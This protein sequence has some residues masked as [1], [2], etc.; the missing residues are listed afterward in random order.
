MN[1]IKIACVIVIVVVAFAAGRYSVSNISTKAETHT[2]AVATD[3]KETHKV[4]IITKQPTGVVTDTITTDIEDLKQT[5]KHSDATQT[6]VQNKVSKINVSA[7]VG[8]DLSKGL[9]LTPLYGVSVSKD[10][11]GPVSIGAFGLTNGVIGVSVGI[12]F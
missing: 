4:E 3:N 1:K 6:T 11:I 8:T 7:L 9:G 2:A 10:F 12:D 5:T